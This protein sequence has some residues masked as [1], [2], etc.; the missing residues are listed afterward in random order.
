[1][2]DQTTAAAVL[3]VLDAHPEHSALRNR[4]WDALIDA[5]NRETGTRWNAN[6]NDKRSQDVNPASAVLSHTP[7]T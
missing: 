2:L 3:A 7:K 1:M 4:V 5:R 6:A